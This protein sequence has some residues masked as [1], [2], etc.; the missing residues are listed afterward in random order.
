M[1]ALLNHSETE[2]Q[3]SV[4]SGPAAA[5]ARGA[6][7]MERLLAFGR[8]R[9]RA[10]RCCTADLI[11]AAG[12]A[13]ARSYAA[14]SFVGDAR[15]LPAR[16]ARRHAATSPLLATAL[17]APLEVPILEQQVADR[18]DP[19]RRGSYG[20]LGRPRRRADHPALSAGELGS[21]APGGAARR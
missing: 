14:Y 19:R 2:W 1:A 10:Q 9:L 16:R 8:S 17:L 18:G 21:A 5:R 15:A 7:P 20:G 13:G 6:D 3:A 11:R 4:I 12:R